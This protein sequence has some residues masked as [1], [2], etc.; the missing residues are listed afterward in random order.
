MTYYLLFFMDLKSRRVNF[1]GCTPNP[2]EIWMRQIARNISDFDE[3]LP[4][5]GHR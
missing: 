1:A 4:S 5:A 3:F 2:D